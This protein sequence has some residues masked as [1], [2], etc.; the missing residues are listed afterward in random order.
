MGPKTSYIIYMASYLA[1]FYSFIMISDSF[2]VNWDLTLVTA[3]G[4]VLNF[5]SYKVQVAYQVRLQSEIA[6]LLV[7]TKIEFAIAK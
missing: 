4:L 3:I 7:F 2:V 1:T 5:T 6:F